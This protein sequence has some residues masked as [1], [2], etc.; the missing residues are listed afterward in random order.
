MSFDVTSTEW[1]WLQY[2]RCLSWCQRTFDEVVDCTVSKVRPAVFRHARP[3]VLDV[4]TCSPH[5]HIWGAQTF[6]PKRSPTAIL[7]DE[8]SR[9]VPTAELGIALTKSP[10]WLDDTAISRARSAWLCAAFIT[11]LNF[12]LTSDKFQVFWSHVSEGGTPAGVCHSC[13]AEMCLSSWTPPTV[14]SLTGSNCSTVSDE[15]AIDDRN[16]GR[17][18]FDASL[19]PRPPNATGSVAWMRLRL[20]V[21][22][23]FGLT[24]HDIDD[25]RQSRTN[26]YNYTGRR[27]VPGRRPGRLQ[28]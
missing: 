9:R 8:L 27:P 10:A 11:A 16:A 12:T 15:L 20:S 23:Y 19:T 24:S 25:Q 18:R 6:K 26:L 3:W 21:Y 13:R 4:L 17:A 14:L 28:P 1:C 2:G 7:S 22:G 5:T